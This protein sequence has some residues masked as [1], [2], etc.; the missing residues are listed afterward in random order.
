MPE[1]IRGSQSLDDLSRFSQ[2]VST[3]LSP[4]RDVVSPTSLVSPSGLSHLAFE[5]TI[6]DATSP[7]CAR[8]HADHRRHSSS[9][10]LER[11]DSMRRAEVEAY[12]DSRAATKK[13]FRRRASTLQEYYKANPQLLL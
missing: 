4:N 8:P 10:R 12:Y 9:F 5:S 1:V 11:R 7:S 6:D 3:P 13:E 2:H